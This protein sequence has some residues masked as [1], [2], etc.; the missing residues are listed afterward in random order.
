MYNK[1]LNVR[2]SVAPRAKTHDDA[3]AV[4]HRKYDKMMSSPEC[5]AVSKRKRTDGQP[6]SVRRNTLVGDDGI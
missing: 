1:T 2:L 4:I 3:L 5:E 6:S